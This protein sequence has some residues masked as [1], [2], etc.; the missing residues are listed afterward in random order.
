MI[1]NN[2]VSISITLSNVPMFESL[3]Q[4]IQ[5]RDFG[6]P[7]S[8]WVNFRY[9]WHTKEKGAWVFFSVVVLV[10]SAF[11]GVLYASISEKMDRENLGCLALNVY[12]EAR[13]EPRRGQQAV[14]QVTMN[15]VASSRYPD[16][17]CDVVY[18]KNWDRIRRRDVG[19]FS[20]TE[21]EKKLK[22]E[23]VAWKQAWKVAN[24]VYYKKGHP[25]LEG[26]LFYHANYIKPS[27]T[28]HKK[29]IAKIGSHIFYR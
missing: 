18:E 25:E 11:G 6:S 15:R 1:L 24:T 23:P 4:K 27:W 2:R 19:A 20:W 21:L 14:A 7:S 12:F 16:N 22:L 10:F 17:V 29:P 9:Y 3:I 13:G 28:R 5:Y 26:A 8:W